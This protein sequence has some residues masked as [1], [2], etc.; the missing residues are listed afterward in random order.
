M[1][2]CIKVKS[3][4]LRRINYSNAVALFVFLLS[5]K[6]VKPMVPCVPTNLTIT[7]KLNLFF[8]KL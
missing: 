1:V 6:I 8:F 4:K 7:F 3:V 2:K 5:K